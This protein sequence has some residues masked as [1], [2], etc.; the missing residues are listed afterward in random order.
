MATEWYLMKHTT[1][2]GYEESDLSW[3]RQAFETDVLGS[4]L[5]KDVLQYGTK[6][7]NTPQSVRVLIQDME[8]DSQYRSDQRTVLCNIG[9]LCCGDYLFFENR[10]W[11][12]AGLVD[13]NTVYEKSVLQYC[14]SI[15]HFKLPNTETLVSYPVPTI[16]ATQYNSGEESRSFMT[17]G[18]SQ[19]IMF[20]PFNDETIQVDNDFRI[21]M[22]KNT[23]KPTAWKVSQV[24]PESYA[25]DNAGLIRWTVMEDRLRETD[26]IQNMVADNNGFD[27]M[28]NQEVDPNAEGWGL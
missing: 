12:V 17:I 10:W 11:L 19:R 28:V 6:I 26:D 15:I 9:T 5:A 14:K 1:L 3:Q 25:F 23:G 2:G 7:S 8:A 18:S 20:V 16:N 24:D 22:D 13:N 4:S 27:Q 21:L